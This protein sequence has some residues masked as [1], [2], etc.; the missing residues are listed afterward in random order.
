M[1]VSIQIANLEY[2]IQITDGKKNKVAEVDKVERKWWEEA[3][4]RV[5]RVYTPFLCVS[6]LFIMK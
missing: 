1:K 6:F 3:Y 2:R 5:A 4:T